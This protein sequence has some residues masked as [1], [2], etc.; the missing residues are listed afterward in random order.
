MRKVSGLDELRQEIKYKGKL[1]YWNVKSLLLATDIDTYKYIRASCNLHSNT[2]SFHTWIISIMVAIIVTPTIGYLYDKEYVVTAMGVSAFTVLV[3]LV[4]G[5]NVF[6][7]NRKN[8]FISNVI[9]DI[10]CEGG[11]KELITSVT[12]KNED[13]KG[14]IS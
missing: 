4:G 5:I 7:K 12:A 10:E 13:V 3:I 2:Q 14:R 1:D 6:E 9:K 8:M 11:R